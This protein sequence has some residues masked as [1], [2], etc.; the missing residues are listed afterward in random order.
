M[1]WTP[2]L[3]LLPDF[4]AVIGL[5]AIVELRRR[6]E[7]SYREVRAVRDEVKAVQDSLRP[8]PEAP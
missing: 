1:N 2:V 4:I 3:E 6:V 7:R 5:L 8:P